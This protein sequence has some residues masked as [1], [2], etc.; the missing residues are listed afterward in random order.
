MLGMAAVA[1]IVSLPLILSREAWR[2][3]KRFHVDVYEKGAK[4]QIEAARALLKSGDRRGASA[5][6]GSA[7]AFIAG[8][9]SEQRELRAENDGKR[10]ALPDEDQHANDAKLEELW[11]LAYALRADIAHVPSASRA[12][13]NR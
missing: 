4:G 8:I 3:R 11:N 10:S 5:M 9:D 2:Q 7:E 1:L 13:A 6:L 12:P